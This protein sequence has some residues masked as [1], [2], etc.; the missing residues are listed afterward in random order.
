MAQHT[1]N[2]VLDATIFVITT[3]QCIYLTCDEM[4]KIDNQSW[5]LVHAFVVHNWLCKP[6]FFPLNV[7][8]SRGG[9]L[10]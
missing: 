9:H 1:Q 2:M 6:L 5:L 7:C 4:S 10:V 3:I 8:W